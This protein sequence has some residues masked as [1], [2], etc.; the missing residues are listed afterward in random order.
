MLKI[1][2]YKLRVQD[3]IGISSLTSKV[4]DLGIS[5]G[6]EVIEANPRSLVLR[7][8][9]IRQLEATQILDD[10]SEAKTQIPTIERYVARFFKSDTTLMFSLSNPPRGSRIATEILELVLGGQQ[11]FVEPLE[12]S[13][14]MIKGH[15]SFFDSAKLVSAKIRDFRVYDNA[16][17]R[18]EI[19]SKEGLPDDIAPFLGGKY[20]KIDSLT[21]EIS[22]DLVRG[23]I[24]Y[25]NSGTVRVS[26]PLIEAA[27]P[28]FEK[29][30]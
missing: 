6:L 2:Y 1:R 20:F 12:I 4:F 3:R 11:Y 18:L 29:Q 21:Y 14:K 8:T 25:F 28:T 17:G 5:S 7:F 15:I 19:S 26:G 30:L 23:L 24:C 22:H 13:L 16:V 27:F 9:A 10:G